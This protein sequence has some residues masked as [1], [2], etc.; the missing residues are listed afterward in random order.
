MNSIGK[1]IDDLMEKRFEQIE[2]YAAA[3]I[4]E[5]GSK[6]ASKYCLVERMSEDRLTIT[7]TFE[8]KEKYE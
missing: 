5:T 8:L 1:Q 7:W 3:F 6:E 2:K 4:K